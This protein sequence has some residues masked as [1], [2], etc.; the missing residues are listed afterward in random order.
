MKS[1]PAMHCA[2]VF[3]RY[4]LPQLL[5]TWYKLGVIPCFIKRVALQK[6]LLPV[7]MIGKHKKLHISYFL[8]TQCLRQQLYRDCQAV[9]KLIGFGT[10]PLIAIYFHVMIM[11]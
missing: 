9:E 7:F 4:C 1:S 2:P 5:G 11:K 8:Q 6:P 10:G 3:E